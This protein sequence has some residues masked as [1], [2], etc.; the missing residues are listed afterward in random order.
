MKIRT[1]EI[2]SVRIPLERPYE[3]SR[4]RLSAFENVVLRL[5]TDDGVTGW[6]EAVPVSLTEAPGDFA[7]LL[8]DVVRPRLI[9]LDLAGL[10]ADPAGVIA[11]VVDELLERV[12]P[13]AAVVAAADQALWDIA[14]RAAGRSVAAL[15]GAE[16]GREIAIDYTLGALPVP[17]TALRAREVI[18]KGYRGV[19]VKVTCRDMEADLARV[20]ET[21]AALPESAS[22]RVDANGG[23]DRDGARR[24]LDAL[25]G[26]RIDYV[27]QPVAARDLDGMRLC[28]ESGV[29]IAADESLKLPEDA[30]ALV[31][32]E[33]CDV[34][35][36]KVTKAGG[37]TQTLRVARIAEAAGLPLVIGGGL[38]FG[39]SRFASRILAAATPATRGI[40]HQGPGPASQGLA[41]DIT[42]P[43]PHP[44][45]MAASGG[46]VPVPDAPGLGFEIDTA[47][48]E[49]FTRERLA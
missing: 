4:G 47:A 24:F 30:R 35:N 19:V 33:A 3:I 14:G 45:D 8:R 37:L 23:F 2:F 10:Q 41:G 25:R 44:R 43:A 5:E 13:H 28:R 18:A 12:G 31:A 46:T 27:E 38:T 15:L 6:G 29:P 42:R 20:R 7:A 11:A 32:E 21:C 26:L 49:R 39:I 1:A 34:L 40:C 48:L 22:I 17:E 16:A 9:G 36:V